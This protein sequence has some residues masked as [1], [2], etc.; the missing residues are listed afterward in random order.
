MQQGECGATGSGGGNLNVVG[1]AK[2]K[3]KV[4]RESSLEDVSYMATLPNI[5]VIGFQFWRR[6]EPWVECRVHRSEWKAS[7]G[8][9][10]AHED[11][12]EGERN[13][14]ANY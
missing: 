12:A 11:E 3:F 2:L 6:H 8:A 5:M 1:I 4:W 9:A 7:V 10:V 14:L 13:G